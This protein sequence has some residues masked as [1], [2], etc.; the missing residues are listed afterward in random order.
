MLSTNTPLTN[1]NASRFSPGC[2]TI[3]AGLYGTDASFSFPP[4]GPGPLYC[5]ID[6]CL[7]EHRAPVMA[8]TA[9]LSNV[10]E[11]RA[12]LEFL[13]RYVFPKTGHGH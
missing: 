13:N 3:D 7:P 11:S 1:R 5:P 2:T 12:R 10:I 6:N 8:I 4:P 9:F